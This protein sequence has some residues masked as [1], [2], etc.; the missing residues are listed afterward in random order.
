VRLKIF[1]P[2]ALAGFLMTA[3][4]GASPV[5]FGALMMQQEVQAPSQKAD[6]EMAQKVRDALKQNQLPAEASSRI[7]VMVKDGN[8]TLS[9]TVKT[10]QESDQAQQV[11]SGVAGNGKVTNSIQVKP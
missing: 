8:V 5:P 6:N 7:D 1:T 3:P 4:M 11:A 10:Q 2:I 9:G